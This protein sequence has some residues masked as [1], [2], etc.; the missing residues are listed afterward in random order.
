MNS[1]KQKFVEELLNQMPELNSEQY[2]TYS[3]EL[4]DNLA[5]AP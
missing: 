4:D 5:R 1:G 3:R 2:K